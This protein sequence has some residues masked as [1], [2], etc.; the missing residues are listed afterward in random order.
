MSKSPR[1]LI[2][3]V[4]S[5]PLPVFLA[6]LALQPARIALVHTAATR[7]I[8]DLLKKSLREHGVAVLEEDPF[9]GD[10]TS[11]TSVREVIQRIDKQR[12]AGESL[13][14]DY[15]G[16]T[17]VMAAHARL[18]CRDLGLDPKAA[19]YLDE[20]GPTNS[21]RL[22]FD[23]GREEKLTADVPLTVETLLALHSA[24][25]TPRE[26]RTPAP[27]SKDAEN[28]LEAV[29]KD[30]RIVRSKSGRSKSVCPAERVGAAPSEE[31]APERLVDRLYR[32]CTKE[33]L[34]ERKNP[35]NVPDADRFVAAEFGLELS[36]P[37]FPTLQQLTHIE[38]TGDA[39]SWLKQWVKFV[40]GEWLEEW[41]GGILREECP[42]GDIH[43]GIK[44]KRQ[45]GSQPAKNDPEMEL[46]VLYLRGHR[47][48]FISCTTDNAK[49]I[50]KSKLFE[51]IVRSQQLG[52][53]LAR[54]AL[55]CLAGHDTAEKLQQEIVDIW[56]ASNTARVFSLRDLNDWA[57]KKNRDSIQGWLA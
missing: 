42:D 32:A 56:G 5:S 22:R 39:Q 16:G 49:D 45:R 51:V 14:L 10:A 55:V 9:I 4:G 28:I 3:L 19:S 57:V 8:K 7:Q 20:G 37:V 1:L 47:S 31:T 34:G 27:K 36:Q 50:C 33:T 52:G 12:A 30:E 43:V 11:A 18:A 41:V 15:T 24:Y 23:D 17:K 6:G 38:T 2:L 21:P 44:P 35:K 53:D 29:L 40:K 48:Y 13:K 46:D 54:A 25:S 26:P